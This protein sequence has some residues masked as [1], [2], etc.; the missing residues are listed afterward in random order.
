MQISLMFLYLIFGRYYLFRS[1]F[2]SAIFH[3]H[4]FLIILLA[5]AVFVNETYSYVRSLVHNFQCPLAIHC[6][7]FLSHFILIN[8]IIFILED[9]PCSTSILAQYICKNTKKYSEKWLYGW[10]LFTGW[11]WFNILFFKF[12]Q[13]TA[14]FFTTLSFEGLN[15]VSTTLM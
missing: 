13:N 15:I 1:L 5:F 12:I 3:L 2:H 11:T 4:A 8:L 6:S 9:K 10:I 7:W 14:L